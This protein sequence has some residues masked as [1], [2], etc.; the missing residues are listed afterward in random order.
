M[1]IDAEKLKELENQ[2]VLSEEELLAQKQRLFHKA[3]T[4]KRDVAGKSGYL[5]ILLGWFLGTIGLHNFYAGYF[6]RGTVQMLLTLTSWLFAFIPLL[7]VAVWAFLEI[8]LV[9]H[10]ADGLPLK[11]RRSV[12]IG[13][14]LL[15]ILWLAVAF[16]NS[17]LVVYDNSFTLS[18]DGLYI[19]N[20]S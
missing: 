1:M 10:S 6:W 13:L 16:Y 5:Y 15:T 4:D 12:I 14:R 7:F 19:D 9:N 20:L 17:D 11:G 3:I 18:D 2:G 8:L